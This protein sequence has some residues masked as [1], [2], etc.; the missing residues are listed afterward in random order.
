MFTEGHMEQEEKHDFLSRPPPLT[1][2][3]APIYTNST[4]HSTTLEK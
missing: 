1:H 3:P 2:S 4:I